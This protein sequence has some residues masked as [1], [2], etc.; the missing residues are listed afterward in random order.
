MDK[1]KEETNYRQLAVFAVGGV[2][3]ID[4]EEDMMLRSS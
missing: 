1:E 4:L 2:S 3:Q